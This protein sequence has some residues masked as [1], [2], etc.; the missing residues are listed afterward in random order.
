MLSNFKKTKLSKSIAIVANSTWNIQNF[1]TNILKKFSKEGYQIYVIAP[2]DKYI[3]YKR[4]FPD[5]QHIPIRWLKRDGINP[6]REQLFIYELYKIYRSIRPNLVINYT[7]KPNIYGAIAA[8]FCRIPSIGVV[9]GLGYSFMKKG[10]L[11]LLVR[12]LYRFANKYHKE[13]IFENRDDRIFFQKA[14]LLS[15]HKGVSVKGCGVDSRHF[16]PRVRKATT[17]KITFTFIGRMIYDK[18]IK[19]F[20]EAARLVKFKYP[21]ANFVMVGEIDHSN[22]AVVRKRQL[23]QWMG[24]GFINYLGA[25]N[26]IRPVIAA[27][28]CVVLPSYREAIARSL[29]E[30]MS[31]AKPVIATNVA[32]CRETVDHGR[33][34]FLVE[35]KNTKALADS[36]EHFI[37]LSSAERLSLGKNGRHKVLE[38]Y[39]DQ[40][41]ANEI[42]KTCEEVLG[43]KSTSINLESRKV[44]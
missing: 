21:K 40:L 24:E 37:G 18:G 7:V 4:H 20:V 1:R 44:I 3:H 39:D 19:E 27:A 8:H 35:V 31:M 16:L 2:V 17:T 42:F 30:A 26:D 5:I 29:T 32:G 33:N 23:N 41:I 10:W 13:I 43:I 14:G 36:M 15:K 9:T 25:V 38:E 12:R 22:P 34:G 6:I 11:Q 28:D